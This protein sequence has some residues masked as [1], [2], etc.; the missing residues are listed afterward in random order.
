[1]FIVRYLKKESCVEVINQIFKDKY[2]KQELYEIYLIMKI[3]YNN[4]SLK[5]KLYLEV[6][7]EIFK[8]KPTLNMLIYIRMILNKN[9][10]PKKIIE[11]IKKEKEEEERKR[12]Y[13]FLLRTD[14]INNQENNY[15]RTLS[16]NKYINTN[17][18]QSLPQNSLKR[19][20]EY[21]EKYQSEED[22]HNSF[23]YVSPQI[24][25]PLSPQGVFKNNANESQYLNRNEK[26]ISFHS[27]YNQNRDISQYN[28]IFSRIFENE[29][30]NRVINN[31]N[32]KSEESNKILDIKQIL[33]KKK[34]ALEEKN[35]NNINHIENHISI[36]DSQKTDRLKIFKKVHLEEITK[37]NE[38]IKKFNQKYNQEIELIKIDDNAYI[39]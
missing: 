9:I 30:S 16:S 24:F 37:L 2:N 8:N 22:N 32:N 1:M 39:L 6:I 11:E 25:S 27:N 5:K 34:R 10:N 38:E 3:I 12:K 33:L 28:N 17:E 18:I 29:S 13:Y 15:N 21:Q 36:N 20:N 19:E 7:Q 14:Y 4:I 26:D 35:I 23:K 31:H